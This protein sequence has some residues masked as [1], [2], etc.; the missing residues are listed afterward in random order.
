MDEQIRKRVEESLAN[1]GQ[2]ER[3]FIARF[4]QNDD[5]VLDEIEL[6][7][8]FATIRNEVLSE[9]STLQK[10]VSYTFD[11]ESTILDRYR[12]ISE[13]GSG[14]QSTVYLAR[15]LESEELVVV[16]QMRIANLNTWDAFTSFQRESEVLS[17]LNLACQKSLTFRN[18]TSKKENH[19]SPSR[20]L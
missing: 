10:L 4:D 19:G 12:I 8:A 13:L 5:G 7:A 3:A 6:Q 17:T 14:A 1:L 20:A 9:S 2:N 11:F 15:D 18:S 16:K